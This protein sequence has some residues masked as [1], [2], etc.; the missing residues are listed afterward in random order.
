MLKNA[1]TY[2]II[3]PESIGLSSS[4][5]VLGKH[6][7]RHAFKVKLNELG[8]DLMKKILI[9]FLSSLKI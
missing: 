5:L 9:N 4:E 1:N 2:E 7:G 8:Y 3:T 6:S